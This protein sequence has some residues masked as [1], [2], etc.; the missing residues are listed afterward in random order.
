MER[1]PGLED[2]TRGRVLFGGDYN[3]EQWPEDVWPE[4]V[5]LMR[6]AD[7]SLVTVGVF[8]WA[9]IEPRPGV[10]DFGWLDT[11]LG[12][13]DDAG[14][15]VCLATPTA[16]PPP[17]L[18]ARHPETLPRDR[19]GN[20]VWYGSR[21]QFCASSPVY[22][23]HALAVTEAVAARYAGHPALRLWHVGNE[24]GT[25]C[26]C[27][28]T[29]RH[30]RRW[31]RERHG[32]LDAL[33]EA[34]GTAFWSQGYGDWEE[35][36]PPRQAQ[37]M[38]SPGQALDFRRF[39]SD[40]L[41]ECFEA[42]RDV[43][44]RHAPGVP[45]TTNFMPLFPGVDGWRWAEREDVVS[46]DIY[47]DP[48]DPHAGAYNALAQDLT[49]SQAGGPWALL[50]Q[51]AGAV[52]WRGVNRPKPEGLT[53]LWSLQA[54]ARGA[55]AVCFFQW[56]QS[57]QGS[58]KFHSAMLPHAGEHSRTFRQVRELG[59]DLARIGA[60][61]AGAGVP[62]GAAV[63]HDWDS[64]WAGLGEGRPSALLDRETLLRA[65]HQALWEANV[66]TDFAR[67]E[68]DLSGYHLVAVPHLSL[69][70]DA[71]LD[72]LTSYVREGGTLVC[73]FFTGVTDEDDRVRPGGVDP[74]LRELLGVGT[75]HDW[76]PLAEGETVTAESALPGLSDFTGTL[77]SEDLDLTTAEP[78]ARLTG[79]ELDGRPALTR[80]AYGFGTAWYVTT[81][82]E[83]RALRALLARA[84]DEAGVLPPLTRL[85]PGVEAVRRGGLLFLLNHGPAPAGVRLPAPHTDLLTGREY[86]TGIHLERH[87]AA[88]L[89]PAAAHHRP[90]TSKGESP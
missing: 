63:L 29:A 10:F 84:A 31:L 13:L 49:R 72:N 56:R 27:E 85:P 14:I 3:P 34:W 69:L 21:N 9:R 42:E 65:W 15:G 62:A 17:W 30:F 53:R 5:R 33:N 7:V 18:G 16:S 70:T 11:V 48:A 88:V 12:L 6:E 83:P 32:T 73:G 25:H 43:L 22:R 67:P 41:L 51:A 4:D 50:E 75:V 90:P 76:W 37:Y 58:E 78:A 64:W 77:W 81:L 89:R 35:L 36:I 86:E 19:A 82:P 60:A 38:I 20:T 23:E 61:V 87:G 52:N 28:E 68:S 57:R 24:Y 39:T 59:A 54:V 79:G 66:T 44:R 47:P 71:A 45:V 26:W 55:D 40:A 80:N 1:G 74:R 2:A 46:A 8:S